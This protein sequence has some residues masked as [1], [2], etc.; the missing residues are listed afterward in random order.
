MARTRRVIPLDEK[1]EKAQ[2]EVVK[3]KEKYERYRR[4][5]EAE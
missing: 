3:A 5:E 1:I 4:M 2:A